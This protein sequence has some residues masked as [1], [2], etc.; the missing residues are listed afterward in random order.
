MTDHNATER[1]KR[2]P[3][4]SGRACDHSAFHVCSASG[5]AEYAYG[6]GVMGMILIKCPRAGKWFS[7]GI[8]AGEDTFALLPE[9]VARR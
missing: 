4:L 9:G 5:W 6:V 8:Q 3:L 2:R 7:T 1:N